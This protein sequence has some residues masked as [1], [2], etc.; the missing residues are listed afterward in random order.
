[1]PPSLLSVSTFGPGGVAIWKGGKEI[2][3]EAGEKKKEIKRF[4]A[5]HLIRFVRSRGL[6]TP[7]RVGRFG[8]QWRG[9]AD[10]NGIDTRAWSTYSIFVQ[11]GVRKS[12]N[13]PPFYD[14]GFI[15]AALRGMP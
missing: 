6:S 11:T 9:K 7:T 10:G 2:G 14:A 1:M 15:F 13:P 5:P 3:R 12:N 8:D 4:Q